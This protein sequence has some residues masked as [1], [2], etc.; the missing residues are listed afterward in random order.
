MSRSSRSCGALGIGIGPEQAQNRIRQMRAVLH[1]R[2]D[3]PRELLQL[4]DEHRREVHD[5][6]RVRLRLEVRSHVDVVLDG[7]Q[8]RPGQDVLARDRASRYCG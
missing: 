8:V 3:S 2:I 4:L 5:G 7:V 1:V 6:A